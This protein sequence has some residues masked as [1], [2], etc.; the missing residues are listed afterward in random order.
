MDVASAKFRI[1]TEDPTCKF[2]NVEVECEMSLFVRNL[3]ATAQF[4]VNGTGLETL[5]TSKTG[6]KLDIALMRDEAMKLT[7]SG[8]KKAKRRVNEM[9]RELLVMN[10][11]SQEDDEEDDD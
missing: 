3:E 8:Y 11:E 6:K 4:T 1:K 9:D 5:V 10:E 7:I 2:G